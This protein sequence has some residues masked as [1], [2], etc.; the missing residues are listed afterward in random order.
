[1]TIIISKSPSLSPSQ[2]LIIIIILLGVVSTVHS[3]MG[4][5]PNDPNKYLDPYDPSGDDLGLY[6]PFYDNNNSNNPTCQSPIPPFVLPIY[7][8]DTMLLQFAQNIE[9]LE[10]DYFLWGALGCGLDDIAPQLTLGGPPPIGVRKANLDNLTE[11][12]IKEFGYEEVGH[13]RALKTTVGGIPRP[14][15]DLSPENFA[16]IVNQ[17]FEHDL[18]PPFDPYRDS[19][20]YM[21][22]SYIIPYMGLNGYVGANPQIRGYVSKRLLAGLLGVE[23]GQDAVIR[24]YLYERRKKIVHPYKFTVEEFTKRISILRNKLGMCGIKD[25]GIVVPPELGPEGRTCTNVLSSNRDS[26]SYARTP[27]EILRV[28]YESGNEH[29]PGGFY[30]KGAN[31]QI[32]RMYLK[33]QP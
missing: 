15:M 33:D 11:S 23:A 18:K 16:S 26:L 27:A 19:L 32:A 10:A 13:L 9:H 22:A 4:T 12:I 1:M 29:T 5:N 8:I 17:A 21:L 14:L 7:K 20:S 24:M 2:M 25:E 28:L 30:P 6:D 3:G 31:G